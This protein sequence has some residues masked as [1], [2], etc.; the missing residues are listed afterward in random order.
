MNKEVDDFGNSNDIAVVGMACRF[1]GAN[2]PEEFWGL[3]QRGVEALTELTD[4][5]LS[6][7]GV[8][9][10]DLENPNYVKSGMFLD[11]MEYFDP[12][13][14]G[15][16]P[17][18][19]RIMDPQHRHFL[20]CA[21]EALEDGC[22]VTDKF[23]GA[24]GVFAGSGHNVY[25][26]Y[27]L[28]TNPK[29]A[30]EVGD[31]LLRHT[32]NDKDFLTTRLSYALDLKGPSVNIQTA[33]STSLVAVHSAAQ[34]LLSGECDMALAGGVTINL[35]HRQGYLYKENEI[36]SPDGHCR[37]FDA[38]SKG[39]VFGSG[40]GVVVLKRLADAMA[41]GDQIQAVIKSSAINN[42][43]AEKVSYLAPSVEGQAAAI[44]E[45]LDIGDIAPESVSYI[46]CHGTGTQL[47][48]PIEV[49]ALAEAYGGEQGS[50]H[51]C[52]IGSVKSNIGH[53]D[54]AAGVASFIKVVLSLKH[55]MLAPT[56][57]YENPNESINFAGSP[58]FVNAKLREWNPSG[59]RRAG[60]SALGVGGTNAH[61]ILEEA[62]PAIESVAGR[63]QQLLLLSAKTKKSLD[64]VITKYAK[65]LP[66]TDENLADIA[67]SSAV[68]RESFEYR[69][70]VSGGSTA[71]L[72]LALEKA[73]SEV[74]YR[75]RYA[76]SKPQIVFMFAGGGAQYPN[77]GHDL[78][79]SEPVYKKTL[80]Q[81]LELIISTN[82]LSDFTE[83]L[84]P[85]PEL[86]EQAKQKLQS[87]VYAL[88]A[89]F[90]TQYAQATLWQE[91]GVSPDACIGHSM[92]EYTA[93]C[94]SGVFSLQDAI[95][96]VCKRAELFEKL[97]SGSMLSVM[98][99]PAE[100]SP[101]M[102]EG[103]SIAAV[104]A[105]ELCVVSGNNDA[106]AVFETVL[107]EKSMDFQR[108]HISVAA[109]S[110]MLEPILPEFLQFMQGISF[111][112]PTRKVVSNLSG[113]WLSDD[114]ITPDYWV[115]HLRNTVRF[116][117]G[118]AK[119]A[120]DLP[121][122]VL[123]EIGSGN[124]LSSL[125]RLHDE[126]KSFYGIVSSMRHPKQLRNDQAFMQSALGRLWACG[127]KEAV[128]ALY[129]GQERHLVSMPTYAFDHQ[130]LWVTPG[131][132]VDDRSSERQPLDRWFYQPS[133]RVSASPSVADMPSRVIVLGAQSRG[134]YEGWRQSISA[135]GATVM[136]VSAGDT[137]AK[138]EE[139]YVLRPNSTDDYKQLLSDC[140]GDDPVTI[141]HAWTLADQ[142]E[143][144]QSLLALAQALS[145]QGV[146]QCR[147]LLLSSGSQSV[148]G[149]PLTKPEHSM[150]AGMAPVISNELDGCSLAFIDI[151]LCDGRLLQQQYALLNQELAIQAVDN[152]VNTICIRA[153]QRY[154][155]EYRP[156]VL[157][158]S[159]AVLDLS[160]SFVVT[161]GLG[162]LGLQVAHSLAKQ[163]PGIKLALL[164]RS[165]LP[166]ENLW[167]QKSGRNSRIGRR[168]RAIQGLRELGANVV[169][170]KVNICDQQAVDQAIKQ[171]VAT[172]GP[173]KGVLHTAGII[174]D[175]LIPMKTAESARA[176]I[177]PKVTG[178][179]CLENSLAEQPL[180][181]ILLYSSI[182]AM[183]GSVGQVDY[184]AANAYLDAFAQ[185]RRQQTGL[186]ICSI[187]WSAWQSIGMAAETASGVRQLGAGF[188]AFEPRIEGNNYLCPV[189]ED[190]WVLDDHRTK[191]GV[192]VM[193][194]TG[195]LQ[196]MY[197]AALAKYQPS[198][199]SIVELQNVF[200]MSPLLL[201]AGGQAVLGIQFDDAG[202]GVRL[203][204]QTAA[205]PEQASNADWQTMHVEAS[206]AIKKIDLPAI[207]PLADIRARCSNTVEQ[208][209][210]A[211]EHEH[212]D[213][214]PH[215]GCL[216]SIGFGEGESL[217]ELSLPDEYLDGLQAMPLHP[218]MLDFATAAG[219]KLVPN[220]DHSS[221]FLV[222]QSY[223][224]ISIFG[225]L[226]KNI[227]S[228]V[229]LQ[230]ISDATS[231]K[232]DVKIYSE[233]G[234]LLLDIKD[235]LVKRMEHGSL[236]DGSDN[237][238]EL[239][240]NLENAIKPEEGDKVVAR[241]L[242]HPEVSNVVV[243]PYHFD[244]VLSES[245]KVATVGGE[246]SDE[247]AERPDLDE[248]FVAPETLE[249]ITIAELWGAG[250]GV[251][252]I[253]VKDNFFELG[254]HS[255]LL[256]KLVGKTNKALSVHLQI[257][258][259]FDDP[260]VEKWAQL[261]VESKGRGD[262][263][264]PKKISRVSRSEYRR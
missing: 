177:D 189:R 222:P 262:S 65:W 168:I 188:A 78:Y 8:R 137:F 221:E 178:L 90:A 220:V 17:M 19:G 164:S 57:H 148:G 62:E 231:A 214:G 132:L 109:H 241:I 247:S 193:P 21:W 155:I 230:K 166:D 239:A 226:R 66:H 118:L 73:E 173:V 5:A 238:R 243:S 32:G 141:V 122:A 160:G 139:G 208:I 107:E 95:A 135:A 14:F 216:Q 157:S 61:M 146:E 52:A 79:Q 198:E 212:M 108:M 263:A 129:A 134:F 30:D 186:P 159:P 150:M 255:L 242:S 16:S 143:G 55:K 147:L 261:A 49:A 158:D 163:N 253:G 194:G 15:L 184:A 27:N 6:A 94:L 234:D 35:P 75:H 260:T 54:T 233:A 201:A 114:V 213:F 104:N 264:K 170:I 153:G 232:F 225:G 58:F 254:G 101:L 236:D 106:I 195:Y 44:K 38:A 130:K 142:Y 217:A 167:Q 71:E 34:S 120:A 196:Y 105:G 92:G 126:S 88:P 172:Q 37:P 191:A 180:D 235:F 23:D 256:I 162:S 209:N 259:L 69:C 179:L 42:D 252:S 176:V 40:V 185:S 113:D 165:G 63:E 86:E 112:A 211:V 13:F 133:W 103:L 249:Q 204:F 171:V 60:I 76:K 250:L 89:L 121:G 205:T 115:R 91:W 1:P 117:D 152:S 39:T 98:S 251:G 10:S 7:E 59:P 258:S 72:A 56:L 181:F 80:D 244:A 140:V 183:L 48:D 24:V 227:F 25:M 245:F 175:Q 31:F 149:E 33:C 119:I 53:L 64:S 202:D 218:G 100:L 51:K 182:S 151:D 156:T 200:F 68:G 229:K 111:H 9:K 248:D 138:T 224:R 47:G 190:D 99:S 124:T 22:Q 136:A 93:A 87:P 67:Y 206:I 207:E 70:C 43:G 228:H 203:S 4:E 81:C 11:Q 240:V 257:S 187:G 29:L 161:G 246:D 97:P 192:A 199:G 77:M 174:N 169:V 2:N 237:E 127:A 144:F 123:L 74:V 83:V 145:D 116:A 82:G 12:A 85:S 84:F 46:E 223:G 96:I 3:L 41:D 219:H 26:P 50:D 131:K 36:L 18:E 125:A 28:R 215:W 128:D 110:A 197:Q 45:A 102:S 20:E 154:E 210:G